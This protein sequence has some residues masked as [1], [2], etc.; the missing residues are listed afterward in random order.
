MTWHL[1]NNHPGEWDQPLPS[2]FCPSWTEWRTSLS[3]LQEVGVPRCYTTIPLDEAALIELHIFCDASE[4]GIAAVSYLRSV[5][6]TGTATVSFVFGKAKLAPSHATTMPRLELCAAVLA[7]EIAELIQRET[8]FPPCP[9][10][11]HSDSKVVLGYIR[12][13]TRRFYVYVS[14]RVEIIRRSTSPEDWRYVPT[15]LN[16]A[17]CATRSVKASHLTTSQWLTGPNFLR[18]RK[19]PETQEVNDSVEVT[20]EDPE[21]RPSVRAFA[22]EK[23]T[24]CVIESIRF[25]RFSHWPNLVAG[26]AA[27]I[28]KAQSLK[29]VRDPNTTNSENDC[30]AKLGRAVS[31]RKQAENLII[32]SVQHEAFADEIEL[33]TKQKP[34]AKG[35]PLTKL[36]P[37][38]DESGL[39]RVGGR[40]TR[41]DLSDKERH[42]VILPGSHHV[43]TLLVRHHH[44][45]TKHQGRHLT[46]GRIRATGYWIIGEKRLVNRV[47]HECIPC[48]KVRGKLAY[49]KMADLPSERLTPAPPFTYVGLDV[50]GPWQVVTRRTRGGAAKD[51]RWAVIFTCL[52]VRAVHIE[53]I[54]AM[55]ASSFLNAL[56][57]FLALRG[58]VSQFRS[59]CG[60][61]F[62]GAQTE[63]ATALQEMK[64]EQIS[65]YLARQECEWI[66]NPPHA[67]H[68]GGIWERM[69][70]MARKILDAMLHEL[71]TKQLTHEVLTTL[72]AEVSAIMNSRPLT[73]V[74]TDPEAPKILSPSMIL[75]QKPSPLPPPPGKFTPKDLYAAQWR[76][77]Q[78]LANVFWARWKREFLPLLQV[79]RKWT[80]DRPNLREGDLVLLKDKEVARNEWPIALVTQ[81]F[82]SKDSKVRKIEVMTARGGSKRRYNRPVTEVV[83][84]VSVDE[85]NK[86]H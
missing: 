36:N 11:Y 74:S 6:D 81:V 4:L 80:Q 68:A 25:T 8:V 55:D 12:N 15:H 14:N 41:A 82:P 78:Y 46:R 48:R 66:F 1:K 51:K 72:M 65:S 64:N 31:R 71:P 5:D 86:E 3:A 70:G 30:A 43:T 59:D 85:L 50:F 32:K 79:R 47:I 20:E 2:E 73:P 62:V 35:S 76:Q 56:R 49:Q 23:P 52:T 17:D 75:T 7:V 42:P 37:I 45:Q 19:E 77:V 53:I 54:E 29:H 60:T 18:D 26:L 13:Q 27:L 63:L 61:N 40:L 34:L 84:I 28:S 33:I 39:L 58:P 22:T 16:P 10:I 21:V 24:N 83:L 38:V 57:R 44:Q 9:V 67:S 69:I